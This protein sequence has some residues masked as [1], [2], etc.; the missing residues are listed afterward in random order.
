M[1]ADGSKLL[2]LHLIMVHNLLNLCPLTSIVDLQNFLD[3]DVSNSIA[4]QF[5]N[6]NSVE[7]QSDGLFVVWGERISKLQDCL[8]FLNRIRPDIQFSL[9]IGKT[10]LRFL[11]E[12]IKLMNGGL[13]TSVYSKPTDSHAYLNYTSCHPKGSKNGISKGVSLR[14]RRICSIDDDFFEQAKLYKGYLA[15]CGHDP[16]IINKHFQKLPI[17]HAMK[18]AKRNPKNQILP[19]FLY[20]SIIL[21]VLTLKK[22]YPSTR[23]F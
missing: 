20:Q 23:K 12:E 11:D 8:N 16:R 9:V 21:R 2:A 15:S 18:F 5:L 22:S 3:V 17:Y 19:H 7:V 13:Q 6:H 4:N 14:L 10:K 1:V